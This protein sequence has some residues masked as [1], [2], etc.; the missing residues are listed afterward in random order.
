MRV[1]LENGMASTANFCANT[2]M[3]TT[4]TTI[5]HDQLPP[6]TPF[7]IRNLS[8]L[9]YANGFTLWHYKAP[10][11]RDV[12]TPGY[13]DEAEYMLA[14]GDHM[15][16]SASD[17]GALLWIEYTDKIRVRTMAAT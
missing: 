7:A 14:H 2:G 4:G 1:G 15:H 6:T 9:Q 17:G 16:V 12:L 5:A 8:V 13:F 11:I 10:A 3:T